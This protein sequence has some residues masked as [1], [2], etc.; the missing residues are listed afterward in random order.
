MYHD[1][2]HLQRK[3]TPAASSISEHLGVS[4]KPP[5]FQVTADTTFV[6]R[7]EIVQTKTNNVGKSKKNNHE[8]YQKIRTIIAEKIDQWKNGI[9]NLD[10]I[11]SSDGKNGL[12]NGSININGAKIP[13]HVP[14]DKAIFGYDGRG[15]VINSVIKENNWETTQTIRMISKLG[16]P[17]LARILSLWA[18]T[19]AGFQLLDHAINPQKY[20]NLKINE[21]GGITNVQRKKINKN[22]SNKYFL[23]NG[24]LAQRGI[25]Q[26]GEAIGNLVDILDNVSNTLKNIEEDEYRNFFHTQ[27]MVQTQKG[28][29]K[30]RAIVLLSQVSSLADGPQFL[31]QNYYSKKGMKVVAFPSDFGLS[32]VAPQPAMTEKSSLYERKLPQETINQGDNPC[33]MEKTTFDQVGF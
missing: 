30:K 33:A 4:L 6:Q 18:A 24:S 20:K 14:S 28:T 8:M 17:S 7:Q 13:I 10:K 16:E 3:V 19:S 1:H 31:Y 29:N 23:N 25:S 5:P 2:Q 9:T 15:K 27:V 22:K 11:V 26:K 12:G 21:K 32:L